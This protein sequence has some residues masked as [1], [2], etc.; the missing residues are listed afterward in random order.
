MSRMREFTL[1]GEALVITART[2]F[3]GKPYYTADILEKFGG[4]LD[5]SRMLELSRALYK[6]VAQF[7]GVMHRYTENRFTC[8]ILQDF[9]KHWNVQEGGAE[10][11]ILLCAEAEGGV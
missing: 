1:E 5:F 8:D 7:D 6:D 9:E 10:D 3:N 11:G 4:K 2:G